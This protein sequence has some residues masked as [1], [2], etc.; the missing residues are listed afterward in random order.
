V[1]GLL[2]RLELAAEGLAPAVPRQ[3]DWG[4]LRTAQNREHPVDRVRFDEGLLAQASDEG[5]EVIRAP[6]TRL[7][8]A[9]RRLTLADGR[10]V[11][12]GRLVEARGRRAPGGAGRRRGPPTVALVAEDPD[13]QA[14]VSRLE[15]RA[16]GWIWRAALPDGRGVIQVVAGPAGPGWA[17]LAAA[18]AGVTGEALPDAVRATAAEMRLTAPV[19]DPA[20]LRVG[21]AAI[22]IDPLSGHGLFWALSSALILPPVLAAL[23]AGQADLARRFWAERAAATFLRQARVGRDFHRRAGFD[24]PFWA[25]RA[26]WPDDLPPHPEVAAPVLRRCIVVEAGRLVEAEAVV[27][28]NAP[29]GAAFLLGR[30]LVPLLRALAARPATPETLAPLLPGRGAADIRAAADWLAAAGLPDPRLL[31]EL[32]RPLEAVP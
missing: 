14:A 3:V 32:T 19:L 27:T 12:A 11:T 6:V 30:P 16:E 18:W 28:P 2:A 24:T 20:C 7:D 21:D 17:G 10:E 15:A 25:A 9:A 1:A 29:E 31:P 13:P 8:A 23:E 26:A 22:A 4:A 5:V